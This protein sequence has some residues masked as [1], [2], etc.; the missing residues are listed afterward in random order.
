MSD[1]TV[2]FQNDPLMKNHFGKITAWSL[3]YFLN[4]S[5]LSYLAK[6]QILVI[7]LLQW[8]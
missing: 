5:L 3:I 6:L 4:Y 7:S 8:Y 1:Q 2:L